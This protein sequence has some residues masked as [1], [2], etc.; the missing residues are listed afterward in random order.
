M[1]GFAEDTLKWWDVT[2]WSE[3]LRESK[4]AINEEELRPY[5]AL[6]QVRACVCVC[7]C[8]CVCMCVC[9]FVCV[10]MCVCV[11]MRERTH[12]CIRCEHAYRAYA[13]L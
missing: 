2:F 10:C 7:V 11:C 9:V 6:P 12:V 1:Q 5:F 13:W 4:Y 8:V 3:R